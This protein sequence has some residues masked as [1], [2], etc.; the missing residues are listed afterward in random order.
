MANKTANSAQKLYYITILLPM[1]RGQL[2]QLGNVQRDL[3]YHLLAV[4]CLRIA[5]GPGADPVGISEFCRKWQI[6]LTLPFVGPTAILRKVGKLV[7]GWP[8]PAAIF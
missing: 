6:P 1:W 4:E 8:S 3:R 7:G 5:K 2:E